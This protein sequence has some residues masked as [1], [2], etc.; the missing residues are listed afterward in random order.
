[1]SNPVAVSNSFAVVSLPIGVAGLLFASHAMLGVA[2]VGF[3][4]LLGIHARLAQARGQASTDERVPQAAQ[5]VE[6]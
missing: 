5:P 4:C 6:N 2:L 1:M 3:A